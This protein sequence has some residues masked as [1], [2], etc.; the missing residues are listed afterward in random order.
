MSYVG[1]SAI[2]CVS[3]DVAVLEAPVDFAVLVLAV[4]AVQ[5]LEHQHVLGRGD[6]ARVPEPGGRAAVVGQ[7]LLRGRSPSPS[8]PSHP[9]RRAPPASSPGHVRAARI[10][11]R[12][13]RLPSSP[14]GG[15]APPSLLLARSCVLELP[16]PHETT[17]GEA[18]DSSPARRY[19][20]RLMTGSHVRPP[21]L[22]TFRRVTARGIAGTHAIRSRTRPSGTSAP[23][24]S[25]TGTT[26][27]QTGTFMSSASST[28]GPTRIFAETSSSGIDRIAVARDLLVARSSREERRAPGSPCRRGAPWRGAS[29]RDRSLRSP[30]RGRP[31]SGS[32]SSGGT[33]SA[34]G[35]AR[36][37]GS[38]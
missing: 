12:R 16:L 22:L 29:R 24:R 10:R 27:A 28:G 1:W 26:P 13:G 15:S 11:W 33:P 30:C 21:E 35:R 38:R 17:R 2:A 18:P 34:R 23:A 32:S 36:R 7:G 31:R 25:A 6:V 3:A 37:G 8:V 4:R 19:A 14:E 20:R 5:E 9:D